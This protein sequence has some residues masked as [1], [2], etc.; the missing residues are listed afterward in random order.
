MAKTNS[1]AMYVGFTLSN[2]VEESS[3]LLP[4]MFT[5]QVP[6]HKPIK[7]EPVSPQFANVTFLVFF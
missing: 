7:I 3:P 6:R 2:I 5:A 1:M 4:V